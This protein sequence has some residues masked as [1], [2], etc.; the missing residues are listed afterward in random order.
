[1]THGSL[2]SSA[3]RHRD[4]DSA[5]GRMPTPGGYGRTP[6]WLR[7]AACQ[8]LLRLAGGSCS[9]V[10]PCADSMVTMPPSNETEPRARSSNQRQLIARRFDSAMGGARRPNKELFFDHPIKI[11]IVH[12]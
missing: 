2:A 12:P 3:I 4:L 8:I 11:R 6:V 7:A 10:A 9:T 1:M 5:D